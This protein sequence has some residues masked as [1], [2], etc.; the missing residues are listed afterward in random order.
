MWWGFF[1]HVAHYTVQFCSSCFRRNTC[2][3][4]TLNV[5]ISR[6]IYNKKKDLSLAVI[7][8]VAVKHHK[9]NEYHLI[10]LT[11][12]STVG[13]IPQIYFQGTVHWTRSQRNLWRWWQICLSPTIIYPSPPAMCAHRLLDWP[14]ALRGDRWPFAWCIKSSM[15]VCVN[16]KSLTSSSAWPQR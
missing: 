2:R 16:W 9:T 10:S 11:S 5:Q 4:A 8:R 15:T 12:P 3:G 13:G 1:Q 6:L 14:G 7:L